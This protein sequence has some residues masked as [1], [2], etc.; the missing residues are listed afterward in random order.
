MNK[1]PE[2]GAPVRVVREKGRIE[3]VQPDTK[4]QA[5]KVARKIA[6]KI[7]PIFKKW[8]NRL[9]QEGISHIKITFGKRDKFI[10]IFTALIEAAIEGPE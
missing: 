9:E 6:D 8:N 4:A 7:E 10:K 1:C 3:F 5:K 2:C